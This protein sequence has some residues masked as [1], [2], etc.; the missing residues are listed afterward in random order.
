MTILS[1]CGLPGTP[2]WEKK[3][4]SKGKLGFLKWNQKKILNQTKIQESDGFSNFL[5]WTS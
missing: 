4:Y 5:H 1:P 2:K 3:C